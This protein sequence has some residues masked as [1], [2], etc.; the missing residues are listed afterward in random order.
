MPAR[1]GQ[2]TNTD[3]SEKQHRSSGFS[4]VRRHTGDYFAHTERQLFR[5]PGRVGAPKVGTK[6]ETPGSPHPGVRVSEP[7]PTLTTE[8]KLYRDYRAS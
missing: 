1:Y 3:P 4:T 7:L 5:A 6:C 2:K 8:R